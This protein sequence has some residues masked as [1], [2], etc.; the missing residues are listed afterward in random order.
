MR[1]LMFAWA[2]MSL[3][4]CVDQAITPELVAEAERICQNRGGLHSVYA[5]GYSSFVARCVDESRVIFDI[6]KL[7]Q[8]KKVSYA[9][10]LPSRTAPG[11]TN[12]GSF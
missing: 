5:S 12:P 6:P 3:Y 4:G 7:T 1:N 9:V 10:L 2:L 11:E 8:P